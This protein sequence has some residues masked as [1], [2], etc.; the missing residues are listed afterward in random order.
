MVAA[1]SLVAEMGTYPGFDGTLSPTGQVTLRFNDDGSYLVKV[2]MGGLEPDCAG[3]GVHVHVGGS[4]SMADA[5]GG[6]YWNEMVFESDP[7]NDIGFYDTDSEGNTMNGFVI[8]VGASIDDHMDRTV[9]LHAANGTR[10]ACGEL[11]DGPRSGQLIGSLSAEMGP[12]PGYEGDADVEGL[13]EAHFYPDGSLRMDLYLAGL[14]PNCE[15]CGV[16]IHS[17]STCDD[18]ALVGGHYW[19]ADEVG[20]AADP[21]VPSEGAYY[22]FDEDGEAARSY[23]LY[24]GFSLADN[25]DHAFVVHGIDGVRIGCG[26]LTSWW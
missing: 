6:H 13:V 20:R 3:C 12:Y 4:C 7:W 15:K 2:N 22:T 17:G 14:Q 11:V 8:D 24:S 21:W 19:D 25:I 5:V 10:V 1:E 9:V 18:M 26:V 23:Y 16:H